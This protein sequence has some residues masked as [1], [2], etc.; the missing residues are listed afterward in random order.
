MAVSLH[1]AALVA[2]LGLVSASIAHADWPV[3]RHDA[4][5]S[6]QVTGTSNLQTPAA[7]WR[8]YLGGALGTSLAMPLGDGVAYIGGGRVRLL[9]TL[10]VPRWTS[11]NLA[12]TAMVGQADLDGDGA[13]ELIARSS[14]RAFV[15]E[16][17]TG[18]LLWGEPVG[19]MGTL[20]DVRLADVDGRPGDELTVQECACCQLRSTTP[21]VVWS[22]A[23][24]WAAARKVWT[25]PSSACAG[26]RQMA[27]ADITGDGVADF[28]LSTQTD[29]RILDGATGA[30]RA[31]TPNLGAW[32]AIAHCQAHDVLPGA[33]AELVCWQGSALPA[34]GQ[35]HKVFVVQYRADPAR[36][37]LAWSTDVGDRDGDMIM[38]TDRIV[39]LDHD[40]ALELIATGTQTSG[41]PITTVLDAAT[42]TILATIPGQQQVA[43]LTPTPTEA[44]LVTEASQQLIGWRFDR[45]A[46][47]RTTLA[48]RLKDRR[49][50]TT[51]DPELAGRA[52][53]PTRSV[54]FDANSDGALDLA[55]V[56]TKRPNE[57][58]VYD[59]RHPAD[60]T[61]VAW[62]G[63][64]GS[65]VL[66]A[67]REGDRLVVSTS[68]GRLST[69]T[70]PALADVGSFRAGQYYDHGGWLHLAQAPVA[71]QL[72]GDP[73]A[74]VLVTDSRRTLA[75]LDARNATNADPPQRLWEL[76]SAF[77]PTIV[78]ALGGFPGVMC[79]RRDNGAVPPTESIA[80]LDSTGA[81]RWEASLGGD[82][83][84]D[85]VVG[86]FDGDAVPDVAVQW[87]RASD[88]DIRTTALA[89][90]DGHELW[91]T[92][93]A[94][95]PAKFP[96]GIALADWD[97]DGRDDVVFH[98]YTTFVFS[99][100]TGAIIAT[101]RTPTVTL[102]ML[103]MPI[104]LDADPEDE[105]V[106][107][108]G[109]SPA[110]GVDH[111]LT[112][113]LWT[114]TD[115]RP[116]PYA[117]LVTCAN[118]PHTVSTS[119]VNGVVKVADPAGP[120]L[121]RAFVLADGQLYPDGDAATAAGA[122]LGLL[123]SPVVHTNLTGLGHAS[124]VIGSSD[125]WLYAVDPCA[126]TLD[127][128]VPFGAPVG[129]TAFADTDGDGNDELMVSVADGYLYGL[130]NA[131]LRGPGIVR[132]LDPS[133]A[134]GDDVDEVFTRDTLS[135][136]WD[137]V[138]GA[139]SYEVAIAH[140]DGGY[141][142][143]PPWQPVD[144]TS[145]T[146]TGLVLEDGARYL[147]AVRA[148]SAAGRSPDIL[149]DGVLVHLVG[150]PSVD[151]GVGGP[152][153]G[154]GGSPDGGCCSTGSDP[155]PGAVAA[156]LVGLAL[157]RRRRV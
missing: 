91:T 38:G 49:V 64:P 140:A 22:F 110:R 46:N 79:R 84:N 136:S 54:Q 146:R 61:L 154:T 120:G 66:A 21:G 65:E 141:V 121:L 134:S 37:D 90:T 15:F 4:R 26:A 107:T 32:T 114:D 25:L 92:A 148:V 78:P 125:G 13:P 70:V 87:G 59:A 94:P 89:G 101:G 5:R 143:Y 97:G 119:L 81:I 19:E 63:A 29:L 151:A 86:N 58:L 131:P 20:A 42:G 135:G 103:P 7:Y 85:L 77:A 142:F 122:K 155:V 145:Y 96:S 138:P 52:P 112:T 16:P 6:G 24:G 152:D 76:R 18:A 93:V 150:G 2:A 60:T 75:A 88:L 9:S 17:T 128:A 104:N 50:L 147:F 133:T 71:A 117:A 109:F 126:G 130:K 123:A 132:D 55:T 111:D 108:G 28:V 27:Y 72:T 102:Y 80:R 47:P 3:A 43:A 11:A 67:W 30:L 45:A 34:P 51:R 36:L 8:Q 35:G 33:G 39:D 73:A 149:S 98:L 68:D 118:R 82:A 115:D 99:G 1:R 83:W 129:A 31:V 137:P 139:A 48:W 10:G 74:E 153:A 127:F 14:D 106:L 57:L 44:V 144:A 12:L 113:A 41:D 124:A 62:R 69:V 116:Y 40:G 157:V 56:D 105:L 95:N 23:D 53:L 156:A 100:A